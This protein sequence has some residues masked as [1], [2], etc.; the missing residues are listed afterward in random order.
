MP[1][2]SPMAEH[3]VWICRMRCSMARSHRSMLDGVHSS[4]IGHSPSR[5]RLC[6][7][8]WKYAAALCSCSTSSSDFSSSSCLSASS[9]STDLSLS[10]SLCP[11]PSSCDFRSAILACVSR[12]SSVRLFI[13]ICCSPWYASSDVFVASFSLK[14]DVISSTMWGSPGSNFVS[15]P[16]NDCSRSNSED[17]PLTWFTRNPRRTSAASSCA[18][19]L[20]DDAYDLRRRLSSATSISA[21]RSPQ[22]S[23]SVVARWMSSLMIAS[24]CSRSCCASRCAARNLVLTFSLW[25]SAEC[26]DCVRNAMSSSIFCALPRIFCSSWVWESFSL[27]RSSTLR[28]TKAFSATI[29][30]ALT[31]RLSARLLISFSCRSTFTRSSFALACPNSVS[32]CSTAISSWICLRSVSRSCSISCSIWIARM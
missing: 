21:C 11:L 29:S 12:I 13:S 4:W 28:R 16:V 18:R 32:A 27:R 17:Q 30:L 6:E 1:C 15:M 8:A 14:R 25:S 20:R 23:S 2:S 19:R 7:M 3:A 5:H 10:A 9:S 24:F 31:V 26:V 22:S